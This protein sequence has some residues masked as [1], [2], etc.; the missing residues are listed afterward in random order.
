MRWFTL[1]PCKT[2]VILQKKKKKQYQPKLIDISVDKYLS[3]KI[4]NVLNETKPSKTKEKLQISF[5]RK[6]F[7]I[8]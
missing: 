4:M 8:H 5:H 7:E 2:K 6:I 1:R 3:R